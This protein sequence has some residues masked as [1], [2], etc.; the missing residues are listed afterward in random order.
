MVQLQQ[1]WESIQKE[2]A[3]TRSQLDTVRESKKKYQLEAQEYA[4]SNTQLRAEIQNLMRTLDSK[5][6][7][8]NQSKRSSQDME[9]EVK[10][11]KQ[12]A[13][14]A[15]KELDA[16]ME[17][18]KFVTEEKARLDQHYK[19]LE[20]SMASGPQREVDRLRQE[21]RV[22]NA[23]LAIVAER[24]SLASKIHETRAYQ[25]VEEQQQRLDALRRMRDQV[26]SNTQA[27]VDHVRSE[28][29]ALASNVQETDGDLQTAVERCQSDMERLIVSIR[30]YAEHP[31]DDQ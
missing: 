26:Q 17:K 4:E 21:L 31:E 14:K 8:L 28:L 24:C 25:W 15:R 5:Q 3:A 30:T 12:E 19:V 6:Q 16:A 13:A 18:H 9:S 27:F 22:V 2:L 11:L 20:E 1:D 29:E 10:R 23:Q 7:Q